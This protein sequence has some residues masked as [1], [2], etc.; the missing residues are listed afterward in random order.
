M[1]YDSGVFYYFDTHQNNADTG[2]PTIF[3]E[4]AR[5]VCALSR[6]KEVFL[7]FFKEVIQAR[8]VYG[9]FEFRQFKLKKAFPEADTIQSTK[10]R[11]LSFFGSYLVWVFNTILLKLFDGA[12]K[13]ECTL[14]E[15]WTA[16]KKESA[17]FE[18]RDEVL[19]LVQKLEASGEFFYVPD[20]QKIYAF[21]DDIEI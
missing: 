20:D 1:G 4:Q 14:D 13:D 9:H 12:V 6:D 2:L 16:L 15:L 18:S 11:I 21:P 19:K 7:K 8:K 3:A 17:A 10:V 5:A